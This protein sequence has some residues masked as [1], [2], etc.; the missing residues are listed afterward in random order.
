MLKKTREENLPI[1]GMAFRAPVF[2]WPGILFL[3]SLALF[4]R[5]NTFP[6][7]YHPDE[8]GKIQQVQTGQWNFHHPML[9]LGT[10]KFF[11]HTIGAGADQARIGLAGRWASALFASIA[12]VAFALLAFHY[13][14]LR[15]F[16]IVG[17]LLTTHHQLFELAHYFKEDTALLAGM[18]LAFH[19]LKLVSE[20]PTR[21]AVLYLGASCGLAISG[22]YLGALVILPALPVHLATFRQSFGR[23]MDFVVA[24]QR[25]MTRSVPHTEYLSAFRNNTTPALW[26]FLG[27]HLVTFWR[28]RRSRSLADWLIV[29]FP[30]F[31]ALLLS[32]SP[33][34]ND[35]Y[36]LPAT[37]LFTF[38]AGLG[39]LDGAAWL[40]KFWPPRLALAA[41]AGLALIAQ[42]IAPPDPFDWKTVSEYYRAFSHDDR[43]DLRAWIETNLPPDAVLAQDA[44]ARLPVTGSEKER[45]EPPLRQRVLGTKLAGARG[46]LEEL[47]AA[48][49]TYVVASQNDYGRYFRDAYRARAGGG[50]AVARD[51]EFYERLF[52][53]GELLWS[54]PRGAVIYLHPGLQ[55]Y[56]L[57]LS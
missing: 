27:W 24:G 25:G 32:F 2:F 18:A 56:R 34:A 48:G 22:K 29:T 54:R 6:F 42:I 36:F 7:W 33:K 50:D 49:V 16:W 47:R 53:E 14:G 52:H 43:A 12:V 41:C 38:L 45:R 1:S 3:A 35:R 4:T 31:F 55:L 5:L 40:E 17:L 26:L 13:R 8:P 10:A 37:A 51:R 23:E 9:M 21:A 19:A 11:A 20:R 39:A 15:G 44:S 30:F 28:T 57:P 46:T